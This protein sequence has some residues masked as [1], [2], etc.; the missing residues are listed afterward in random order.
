VY[1]HLAGAIS[2]ANL[3]VSRNQHAQ[4]VRIRLRVNVRRA[5][6]EL[7]REKSHSLDDQL[8]LKNDIFNIIY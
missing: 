1:S 7:G 6:A 5:N 8:T 2:G 3:I 4:A